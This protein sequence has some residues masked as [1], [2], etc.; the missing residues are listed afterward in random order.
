MKKFTVS[1]FLISSSLFASPVGNPSFPELLQQGFAIPENNWIN[2]RLGYEGD[3]VGDARMT[4]T[5]ESSGRVDNFKQDTNSGTVT[6]NIMDRLDLYGVFGSTRICSDWRF[7]TTGTTQRAQVET[8]YQFLWAV[9]A[10]ASLY[11]WGC[12]TLGLGGRYSASDLKPSWIAIN[13]TPAATGSASFDWMQWQVDLDLSYKIDLFI[14]YI[15]VKY[16]NAKVK[17]GT[18]PEAVSSDGSGSL[19]MKNRTPVG[20][21]VGCTLTTG[22]YFM[23]NV[24]GRLIDE[25][26]AT[27]SGDLRF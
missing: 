14:P 6:L 9:G 25:E 1:F 23:L 26:A 4:Q 11:R 18:Y 2:F 22:K 16:L 19:H 24:E 5:E 12:T 8:N 15:G 21:V 27:I 10:R 7:T 17:T 3:F 13:G 20:I